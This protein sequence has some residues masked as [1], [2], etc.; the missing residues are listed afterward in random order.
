[1]FSQVLA[2]FADPAHW[3]GPDGVG[4]RIAEHLYYTV[5]AVLIA[6]AIAAPVGLLVGHTARGGVVLVGSANAMRAL[7]TLGL[8]TFL[9]LLLRSQAAATLVALVVL[10]VPPVLA[11]SYAGVRSVEAGVVDAARGMGMTSAQRLWQVELPG[12]VA[13]LLGGVRSAVLQVVATTTVAAYVGLGG[14]G[15]LLLDGLNSADYPQMAAGALII[16]GLAVL[17]DLLLAGV[18]RLVVPTG[19]QLSRQSEGGRLSRQPDWGRLAA[20]Q[21]GRIGG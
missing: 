14:L 20:T 8:L 17:L 7:P 4:V 19:C 21:L 18:A 9:F 1:M 5:V 13:L 12:A 6:S 2:W 16:A 10:A 3:R 11:G 15:R